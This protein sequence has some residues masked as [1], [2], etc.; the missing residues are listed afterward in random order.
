ML[1]L[2]VMVCYLRL[3]FAQINFVIGI[4]TT[5]QEITPTIGQEFKTKFSMY[6][7][8]LVF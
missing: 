3:N 8:N 1:A 7:T 5:M 6:I 4:T 2:N